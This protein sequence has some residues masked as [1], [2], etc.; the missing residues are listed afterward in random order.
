MSEITTLSQQKD[1]D[2]DRSKNT[3]LGGVLGFIFYW[4]SFVVPFLVY[5]AN[6]ILVFIYTLPLF[7]ALLPISVLIG[8]GL[9]SIIRSSVWLLV[10]VTGLVVFS[11]FAVMFSLLIGW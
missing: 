6:I 9:T 7:L 5:G 4:F 10:L 3:L 8:I 11:L 2:E 1:I